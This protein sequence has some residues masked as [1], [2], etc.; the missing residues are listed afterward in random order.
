ML[1][2]NGHDIHFDDREVNILCK[3]N[4]QSF[5]LK[6]GDYVHDHPNDN[7]PNTKFNNFYGNTI[8]NNMRHHGSLKFLLP[9]TNYT[10]VETWED[11]KLSHTTITQKYFKKTNLLTLS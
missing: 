4:I 1:F 3:H 2:F 6:A 8:M 11:F 5:I 9:H 7:G 10:L